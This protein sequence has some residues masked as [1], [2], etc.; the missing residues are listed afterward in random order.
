MNDDVKITD[1]KKPVDEQKPNCSQGEEDRDAGRF[2]V[3]ALK[4]LYKN[5]ADP[6]IENP[7]GAYK[8]K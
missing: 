6:D 5:S 4:D 2:T 8:K 3:E 1:E 7:E